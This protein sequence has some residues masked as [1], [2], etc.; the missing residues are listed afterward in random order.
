M[1]NRS[2]DSVWGLWPGVEGLLP[3]P[4]D[5]PN[6]LQIDEA[7]RPY[8]CLPQNDPNLASRHKRR[9]PAH[10]KFPNRPFAIDDHIKP[11]ASTCWAPGLDHKGA[12]HGIED[13]LGRPGGCTR[14]LVHRFY[15]QQYQIHGG[16]MDRFTVGSNA[17]GLTQGYYDTRTLPLYQYLTQDPSAPPYVIL[18]RFFHAAFGGSFLNHIWLISGRTP[19]WPDAD[20]SGGPFDQHAVVGSDGSVVKDGAL[21]HRADSKT[22]RCIPPTDAP[23]PPADTACGDYV[24]NTAQPTFP[25]FH[26]D[27]PPEKRLPPLDDSHR[28]IGDALDAAGISWTWYAGGWDDASGNTAG[29]GWTN[30]PGPKCANERAMPAARFP[31]CPDVLFQFHH[32]PFNYFAR[33]GPGT[34]GRA[35]LK[36]EADF[37]ADLRAGRLPPVAFVKPIGAVNE[38]PGYTDLM[39]GNRHLVELIKAVQADAADWPTTAIIVTYDENGGFWDHV[40]P[41]R[42]AGVADRW[43]PGTRIPTM[44]LSPLLAERG[45]VDHTAYDTTSILSTIERRFGLA[46][47]LSSRP[48]VPDLG[49]AFR[50]ESAAG[51]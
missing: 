41:P 17:L 50:R 45:A 9:G 14:D 12:V 27:T 13:G 48:G 6:H 7:G 22:G 1:E 38:H 31:H 44:I 36:D 43:G 32:Q 16:R 2:F 49:N 40:P 5:T 47:R 37:L 35:H 51:E 26:P 42:G 28:T 34:P 18:D 11:S 25:P 29:R 3:I 30:G 33:F 15:Q 46:G 10:C 20:H 8:S 21:T 4:G 23:G 19:V 39:S 24:V